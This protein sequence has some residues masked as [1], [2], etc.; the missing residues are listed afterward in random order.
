MSRLSI[1]PSLSVRSL[2]WRMNAYLEMV[3]FLHY[4]REGY[5]QVLLA[6][7]HSFNLDVADIYIERK[8]LVGTWEE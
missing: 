5:Y 4:L 7:L 6:I 1:K 2:N 8:N 3:L